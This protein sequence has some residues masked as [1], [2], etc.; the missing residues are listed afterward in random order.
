MVDNINFLLDVDQ[1]RSQTIISY[2]EVLNYLD[3]GNQEKE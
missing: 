3:K 1:G 2:N